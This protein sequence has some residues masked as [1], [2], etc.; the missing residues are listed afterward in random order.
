MSTQ[1]SRPGRGVPGRAP[2]RARPASR[3]A[4]SYLIAHPGGPGVRTGPPAPFWASSASSA[5][6]SLAPPDHRYGDR[7]RG[8]DPARA[9]P[10]RRGHTAHV[11]IGL[12]VLD[13]DT[14][15]PDLGEGGAQGGGVGDA[16][17]GHGGEFAPG[18]AGVEFGLGQ[19]GEQHL[20]DGGAVR[21]QPA[22]G[23]RDHADGVGGV[24]L[25]D[26]DDVG[27]LQDRDVDGLV[28]GLGDLAGHLLP[29]GGEVELLGVA[30]AE[31]VGAHTEAVAAGLLGHGREVGTRG[32]GGEQ[33]VD[34]GAGQPEPARDVG[35]GEAALALQ[36]EFEDVH[37]P[38]HRGNQSAHAR[39]PT[40][41]VRNS[42]HRPA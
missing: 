2:R 41:H 29:L 16:V 22:A 20:A 18:Q 28:A 10:D 25:G 24:D 23:G 37:R 33:L 42:G 34:G 6:R 4:S 11:R 8:D 40:L 32:Q 36:E 9:V 35:R 26:V 17:R 7:E 12:L 1:I 3:T 39:P 14:P 5:S 30:A 21:G 38:G 27:V 31:L 13:G 15:G 19:R